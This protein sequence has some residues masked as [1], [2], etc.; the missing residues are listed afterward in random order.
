MRNLAIVLGFVFTM[1]IQSLVFGQKIDIKTDMGDIFGDIQ[2]ASSALDMNRT[3]LVEALIKNVDT[4][5]LFKDH[6]RV[7]GVDQ[8]KIWVGEI[9]SSKQTPEEVAEGASRNHSQEFVFVIEGR[10]SIGDVVLRNPRLLI[11]ESIFG[12]AEGLS[13]QYSFESNCEAFNKVKP[14][15]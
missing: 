8:T 4:I 7:N 14:A 2:K 5:K 3:E 12:D 10:S 1:G 6:C 11:R 9:I 13:K 15:E